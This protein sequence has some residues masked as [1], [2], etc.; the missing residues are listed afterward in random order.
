MG[1]DLNFQKNLDKL[2][3]IHQEFGDIRFGL[4]IQSAIDLVKRKPNTDL[5]NVSSK[6][7]LAC[8]TEFQRLTKEKRKK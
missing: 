1:N 6:E 8:L 3:E 5:H 7:I 4:C 2:K